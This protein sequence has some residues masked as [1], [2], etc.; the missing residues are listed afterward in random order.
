MF[1]S[2]LNLSLNDLVVRVCDDS[3]QEVK[4]NYKH[5]ECLNVPQNP[6]QKYLKI[7]S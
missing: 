3:Y 2:H 1:V 7:S 4:H 6:Q 5:E